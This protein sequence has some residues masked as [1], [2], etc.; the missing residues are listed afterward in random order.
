MVLE[1]LVVPAVAAIVIFMQAV[2]TMMSRRQDH[3]TAE[4]IT[5]LDTRMVAMQN[6]MTRTK[7]VCDR[8]LEM[9]QHYDLDGTPLWFVPRS[10]EVSQ[11]KIVEICQQISNTQVLIVQA[12]ERMEKNIT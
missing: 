11:G 7:D 9:H 4:A 2:N 10:W 5:K 6:E 8:T 1:G 12:I 3:R